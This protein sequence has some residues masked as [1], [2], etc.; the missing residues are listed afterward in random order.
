M[1]SPAIDAAE[2]FVVVG[3]GSRLWAF[4]AETGEEAWRHEVGG[5]VT[6]SPALWENKAYV[7]AKKG[8]LV[9]VE[10]D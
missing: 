10:T 8:D 2:N 6:G 3:S 9:A 1:S 4:D 5:S 7:T